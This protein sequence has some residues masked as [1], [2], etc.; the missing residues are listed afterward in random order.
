MPVALPN[1]D[2]RR[3]ADLV[4]EARALIP[5]Y[6]PEWT[7]HNAS[8][9][10]I[11]LVELFAYLT[12]M[13]LYRLNRVTDDNKRVFL[14]L[15]NGPDW[16]PTEGK[17]LDEEIA[18][19]VVALR[20]PYRAVTAADFE[21]LVL[22]GF[23]RE[24]ERARCVPR[25]NL[26]FED[27]VFRDEDRPGDV[28]V[29]VVPHRASADAPPVPTAD[30]LER[31]EEYLEPRRLVATR[32]NVVGPRYF[33]IGVRLTVVLMPDTV[34]LGDEQISAPI[35]SAFLRFFDPLKGGADGRGWPF[36]RNVY[37]SEIYELLDELPGVDYVTKTVDPQ[38]ATA[39]L[40]ELAVAP[41]DAGRLIFNTQG[42]LVGVQLAP[43]ELVSITDESLELILKRP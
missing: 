2:D 9:P 4:E 34:R 18:E 11:T 3:Y 28:S 14:K 26:K 10:G 21:S 40:T 16:Q 38:D 42:E 36:G 27:A 6:A 20:R 15:L 17:S 30:L 24:I 29:I 19:T 22:A 25:R 31:V 5:T 37:V 35:T 1:L 12:E 39:T 43:D 7:N 8:D 32:V 41:K 23:P 33:E 13:M